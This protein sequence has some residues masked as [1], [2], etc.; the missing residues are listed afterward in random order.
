MRNCV[1]GIDVGTSA[2]K[3]IAV[4]EAARVVASVTEA[5]PVFSPY[6]GWSEQNPSDWWEAVKSGLGKISADIRDY[7]VISIGLSGQ[8]HGMVALDGSYNVIRP[9]ILWNDQRT[10]K[11]CDEITEAAGGL[12]SLLARTNNRMLTGY[13]GGKILWMKQNEPENYKK[14]KIILNPKDYI[15]FKLSG[16]LFT[17]VSDASGTGFFDVKNRKWSAE[18]IRKAGLDI[19]IFPKAVESTEI[20]GFLSEKAAEQTGLESK[21]PIAGGGG[22]AVISAAGMGLS[23]PGRVGITLGTSGVVTVNMPGFAENRLGAVQFFCGNEAGSY[24]AA[25]CMLSAA[26]SYQWLGDNFRADGESRFIDM[27]AAADKV[28]AGSDGLMFLPY[29]NGE[30][31]PVNDSGARG[32]F[33]GITSRHGN[34]HFARSVL[35]GVSLTVRQI[36]ELIAGMGGLSTGEVILAGG[37]AKSPLWRQIVADVLNMPVSTLYGSTEGGAYGAA[38]VAITG[39]GMCSSLSE[40]S[41]LIKRMN[42]TEPLAQNAAV[43]GE[44]Y[45]KY[46]NIY[47]AIK[48]F[49]D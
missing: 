34:G 3:I 4:D 36:Y 37:G 17:D 12:D 25:G 40:A 14:T 27:D 21:I 38:M 8:M 20:T 26:G 33:L 32:A 18:L 39:A 45:A 29:L 28:P 9:A 48:V 13:T 19:S 22:D 11:Q 5:Y 31:C 42:Q 44:I 43:Y 6:P 41:G 35:E 1:L 30:R 24:N 15:R 2:T 46:I 10:V 7:R 47:D 23:I 16:G 49:N